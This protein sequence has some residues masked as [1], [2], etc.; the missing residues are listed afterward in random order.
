M[1][2][3]D[4]DIREY[5]KNKE[6]ILDGFVEENLNGV[7]Y[8]LTIDAVIDND[9]KNRMEY[10]LSPGEVVFVKTQEKL[11]IPDN[12]LGRI[13]E[14]NSLM[15]LGLIV[16]G[17]HYQPGHV[18]YAFLRVQNVSEDIITLTRGMP[19]AQIIFEQLSAVPDVPYSGQK[20]A[21]Y[22]N[23]VEYRGFGKYQNIYE[24][25]VKSV[26]ENAKESVESSAQKIYANVLTLMGI[27]VAIFSLITIDYQAFAQSTLSVGYILVMN[28][29]LALC[30]TLM[31]GIILIFVNRA[32]NKTFLIVYTIIFALIAVAT[33][34]AAIVLI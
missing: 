25:K 8:D 29:S 14:K 16:N 32:K 20:S 22:Q 2:L 9:S 30:I 10:S 23:E 3:V 5:V 6:L 21:S 11:K 28:L 33:V 31:M 34:V 18:T 7:S 15:R 19:V 26:I 4:R 24:Q 1:I 17:P 12:I 27:L 13:A